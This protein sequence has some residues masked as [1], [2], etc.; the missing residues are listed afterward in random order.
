MRG[1]VLVAAVTALL[2]GCQNIASDTTGQLQKLSPENAIFHFPG[3]IVYIKQK[4]NNRVHMEL[5]NYAGDDEYGMAGQGVAQNTTFPTRAN[6]DTLNNFLSLG[7]NLSV[8][9]DVK[10]EKEISYALYRSENRACVVSYRP[11]DGND[12]SPPWRAMAVYLFCQNREYVSDRRLAKAFDRLRQ[13]R[14]RQQ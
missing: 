1:I 6:P 7:S 5:A 12:G 14:Y 11:F 10:Y 2:A 13:I 3:T 4:S 8:D 9:R